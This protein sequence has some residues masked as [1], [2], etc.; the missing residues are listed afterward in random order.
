MPMGGRP[1]ASGPTGIN[2][3]LLEA[4]QKLQLQQQ[5]QLSG[6]PTN[7]MQHQ[8][9]MEQMA[10]QTSRAGRVP[11]PISGIFLGSGFID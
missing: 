7:V 8:A 2:P 9:M 5:Q 6:Y 10:Q 11:S 4:M 1:A 3:L